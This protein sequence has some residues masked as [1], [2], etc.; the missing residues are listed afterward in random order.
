MLILMRC[1]HR[2]SVVPAC[3]A[4]VIPGILYTSNSFVNAEPYVVHYLVQSWVWIPLLTSLS[5][6]RN[7]KD[8]L[9]VRVILS[10]AVRLGLGF[11]RC[12]EEQG[13]QCVAHQL[14][15]SLT[16][17]SDPHWWTITARVG[18]AALTLLTLRWMFSRVR[19][20]SN[21]IVDGLMFVILCHWLVETVATSS[22]TIDPSKLNVLPRIFYAVWLIYVVYIVYL[23]GSNKSRNK[24][25]YWR[26]SVDLIAVV[27]ILAVLLAGDGLTPAI[28]LI[29]LSLVALMF[30]FSLAKSEQDRW[31][32]WP[33]CGF[34]SLHGFYASG[35]HT[36]LPNIP[37]SFLE[38]IPF[39][40]LF[41]ICF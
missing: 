35:H 4:S 36:S 19:Q 17:L 27:S 16:S 29:L 32:L 41:C 14:Y 3:F 38:L 1:W 7:W 11:F 28:G 30:L 22:Y 13:P 23:L 33:L 25:H 2:L 12:R 20:G 37:W 18:L 39:D 9:V 21:R 6:K 5:V 40:F 34:L 10:V 15:R 8:Q 31:M 24:D 26:N